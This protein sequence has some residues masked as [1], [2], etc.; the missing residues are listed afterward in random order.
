MPAPFTRV[1]GVLVDPAHSQTVDF[2]PDP[3]LQT[4][5]AN[6]AS[7][8]P[9]PGTTVAS[10]GV[11]FRGQPI[12]V[13]QTTGMLVPANAASSSACGVLLDDL[14]AYVVARGTKIAVVK[15]GRIRSYA[16]GSLTVGDPVKF[17]VSSTF[18]GFK[19][20]VSGTDAADLL[21]GHAYPTDDGS[22]EN[23][24]SA[25]TTMAL[26]DTIFVTLDCA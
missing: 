23:G 8:V 26:G 15:R 11:L 13:S 18:T 3:S 12:A 10:G 7:V 6:A 22:A 21:V 1:N 4:G 16:G 24:A 2:Y 19:K 20:W 14:T 5:G 17:D 9:I 25:G